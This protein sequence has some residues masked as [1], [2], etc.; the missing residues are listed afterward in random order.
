MVADCG[1]GLKQKR[2]ACVAIASLKIGGKKARL[3][4]A[5]CMFTYH[6]KV[7]KFPL[8]QLVNE[9]GSALWFGSFAIER[10]LLFCVDG[11]PSNHRS[12]YNYGSS[13]MIIL[14]CYRE[15]EQAKRGGIV[16]ETEPD[17]VKNRIH[18]FDSDKSL[19]STSTTDSDLQ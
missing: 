3:L 17:N 4:P 14:I 5:K 7:C 12:S 8:P 2:V 1:R 6:F 15:N 11:V 16:R 13:H 18:V 10:Y 9:L 19:D